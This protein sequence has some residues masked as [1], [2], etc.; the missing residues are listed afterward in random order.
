MQKNDEPHEDSTNDLE[1]NDDAQTIHCRRRRRI[2][3]VSFRSKHSSLHVRRQRLHLWCIVC[4]MEKWPMYL[5]IPNKY[6]QGTTERI[7]CASNGSY[8]PNCSQVLYTGRGE[9]KLCQGYRT[10]DCSK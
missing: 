6:R 10:I 7:T 1:S 8:A 5:S 3:I 2:I 9:G 4:G